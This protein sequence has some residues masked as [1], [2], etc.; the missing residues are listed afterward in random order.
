VDSG[1]SVGAVGV[2]V[3]G[4]EKGVGGEVGR[5]S[6]SSESGSMP[7]LFRMALRR[8]LSPVCS[9]VKKKRSLALVSPFRRVFSMRRR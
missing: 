1:G 5:S 8:E 3:V 4:L 7:L 9:G 2:S 6:S